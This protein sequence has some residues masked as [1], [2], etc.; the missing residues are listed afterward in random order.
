MIVDSVSPTPFALLRRANH[1]QYR[2]DDRA[3]Q[4]FSDYE[5]PVEVLTDECRRVL[6]SISS[7]N[8]SQVSSN[9]QST[10][11]TDAS[12]SRF[13]DIGFSGAF[14]E[15]EEEDDE[16]SFAKRKT[17]SQGLRNAPRSRTMNIGRPTT[18]SWADFLSSGF[19]DEAVNNPTPLLLPP[20]KIL[21]PIETSR[22][23]SSQSHNPRLETDRN[24]EPGELA[25]IIKFDLDDSFWWVW[26]TSL[27][28]E[29]SA[30]RKAAFGRCALIETVIPGGKWLVIEEM[31]KGAAPE[32]AEGAYV[33]EKKSRFG[34]T[35]RGRGMTRRKS[36]GKQ[37][38]ESISSQNPPYKG[39]QGV[40][41]SK[42]SIGPDQHARIQAAAA[43][44]QQKQRMQEAQEKE[45]SSSARRGRTE[46]DT[47]SVKTNSVFTLQPILNEASPAL[48]WANKYDKDVIREAYLANN[49]SGR[50]LSQASLQ[51]NGNGHADGGL[52]S[53]EAGKL[54]RNPPS[55]DRDLP[56]LPSKSTSVEQETKPTV[57]PKARS[58]SPAPLVPVEEIT[59]EKKLSEKAEVAL[60]QDTSDP[61]E[62]KPVM[63]QLSH[64]E[65]PSIEKPYE[66]HPR[67][68]ST[69][70]PSFHPTSGG[71]PE[72]KHHKLQKR[73]TGGAGLRKMFGRNKG[74]ESKLPE[75]MNGS[76]NDTYLQ[77]NSAA[78]G[79]RFSSLRKKSPP[80][81]SINEPS[82]GFTPAAP[83]IAEGD[84]VTPTRSPE[85]RVYRESFE[86]SLQESLSRVDTADA[87][88]ARQAFSSFDQGP[89]EDVPA[90]VPDTP[91]ES[92]D[93]AT[94]PGAIVKVPTPETPKNG[95]E[96][97]RSALPQSD[98]WAQLR[99]NAE[100]AAARQSEE[101]SGGGQSS[102][103]DNDG[104]MS[105]EE[106]ELLPGSFAQD[107][108]TKMQPS[109]AV[110][111]ELRRG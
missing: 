63:S 35:K 25:N 90:F 23:R 51:T 27:A 18:P 54:E 37:T 50:G 77:P 40:G 46:P 34:W 33:A 62:Q 61:T 111:Q 85:P 58:P 49:N 71:S 32:P 11:L 78:V 24:L 55:A 6:K 97:A 108:L 99:K 16:S 29:E 8:Q 2:D 66:E 28:G 59:A 91:V 86:P 13:E 89:L 48:K 81:E 39:I 10:G 104:E 98:R 38:E 83:P 82:P 74:R 76:Q 95:P 103:T 7:A 36:T 1:F 4:R 31:V 70:P 56:K 57:P 79:K 12:W 30:E 105:G 101:Q 20:D 21:P 92:E 22:G 64:I 94:T 14:D 72:G 75:T 5:D 26:I 68:P 96:S 53:F 102:G 19:V 84:V 3:L 80:N 52:L 45:Q 43:Q 15:A 41:M 109:K 100:R 42:T 60:P 69:E 44:L 87:H 93:E 9:K 107:T 67:A 110:W 88:E 106:S 65:K 17:Q 73:N 47:Y